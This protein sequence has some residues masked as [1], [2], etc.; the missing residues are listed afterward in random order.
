MFTI[1]PKIFF[2]MFWRQIVVFVALVVAYG[3]AITFI[4]RHAPD[5]APCVSSR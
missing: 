5:E 4:P 3:L 1:T 2:L